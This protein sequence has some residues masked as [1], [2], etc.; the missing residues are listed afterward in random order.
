M[1][2][3]LDK[4]RFLERLN[5]Y[6]PTLAPNGGAALDTWLRTFV[7][8]R[9][10]RAMEAL[11]RLYAEQE[12]RRAPTPAQL[13]RVLARL[14]EEGVEV[15]DSGR[16]ELIRDLEHFAGMDIF[17]SATVTLTICLGGVTGP[18]GF[19]PWVDWPLE[20]LE[21]LLRTARQRLSAFP[22]E[23][24]TGR[25]AWRDYVAGVLDGSRPAPAPVVRELEQYAERNRGKLPASLLSLCGPMREP[26]EEG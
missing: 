21:A 7:G 11:E 2:S 8:Y 22:P 3:D 1:W 19:Q 23:H 24:F 17:V 20:R 6:W 5:G 26:G 13:S 9:H 12:T 4:K 25:V 18:R 15:K 10:S 16:Q 14:A